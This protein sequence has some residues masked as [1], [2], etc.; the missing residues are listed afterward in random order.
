MSYNTDYL[1]LTNTCDI[2]TTN[3][4]NYNN[5]ETKTL[6][7]YNVDDYFTGST[8]LTNLQSQINNN[9]KNQ[10][11]LS[12]IVFSYNKNI[13]K[14]FNNIP[15]SNYTWTGIHKFNNILQINNFSNV[16][17]TYNN[18]S[19]VL[20][21]VDDVFIYR[22]SP[23]TLEN[24]TLLSPIMG[25]NRI[26]TQQGNYNYYQNFNDTFVYLNTA[27]ELLNKSLISPII[28]DNIIKSN[29]GYNGV[30]QDI[31]GVFVYR[32][33]ID[34]LLNKTLKYPILDLAVIKNN[35]IST[36]GGCLN[37]F[38]DINDTLAYQGNVNANYI[39]QVGLSGIVFSYNQNI[40]K[41]SNNLYNQINNNY[42]NQVGL[43]SIVYFN[44]QYNQGIITNNYLNQVGLSSIVYFNNQYNQDIINSNYINQLGLSG[45]VYAL[46]QKL[47]DTHIGLCH[48]AGINQGLFSIAIG[49]HSGA[50]N[51]GDH[52]VSIGDHSGQT[53]QSDQAVAIGYGAGFDS[54]SVNAV[55]IGSYAG[56]NLQAPDSVAIGNL[57]ATN[58]QAQYSVAVGYRSGNTNQG[59]NSV[60]IGSRS[61][62]YN[63][64]INCVAIGMISSE[65][66]QGNYSNSIGYGSFSGYFGTALGTNAQAPANYSISIGHDSSALGVNSMALGYG[67]NVTSIGQSSVAI[68][69]NATCDKAHQI[70]LGT[71][72]DM[73]YMST[74]IVSLTDN[75]KYFTVRDCGVYLYNSYDSL[76]PL[77]YSCD[78]SNIYGQAHGS[79]TIY[80]YNPNTGPNGSMS[81]GNYATKN[82]NNADDAY[83]VYP[84][85]GITVTDSTYGGT[86]LNYQNNTNK[87]VFVACSSN[88][89]GNS[90]KIYYN[91]VEQT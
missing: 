53:S 10:V 12:G 57:S 63:Q 36:Y 9:Y 30:I 26:I 69:R 55:A 24:K 38:L 61:A 65:T 81:I 20:Q 62:Q 25:D 37:T 48:N 23:D 73:V 41:I 35:Q 16:I 11:G 87:P 29:G 1:N 82:L 56:S 22:Q 32:N 43:S 18:N 28:S 83:L 15:S 67:A 80:S 78:Y 51:Q 64:G 3:I 89:N 39:N 85:Y 71:D 2:E 13:N 72:L 70:T 50:S 54:Q 40:N 7:G 19:N 74:P 34:E 79:G 4:T 6:N 45:M 66:N 8:G 76:Y 5:I 75:N 86:I 84:K 21:D 88:N 52:C 17:K 59:T 27:D 90:C 49:N 14:L 31:D 42:I 68:G 77:Y 58:S 44:N 46:N 60:A 91:G 33:S 47:I